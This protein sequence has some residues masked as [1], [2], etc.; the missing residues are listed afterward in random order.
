MPAPGLPAQGSRR[1]G[2][3]MED[4]G[5]FGAPEPRKSGGAIFHAADAM[6]EYL[7]MGDAP[8]CHTCGAIMVRNGSCYRCMSCGSTIFAV[9]L[10]VMFPLW[11]FKGRDPDPGISIAPM[12]EPPKG[13]S[14]AECGTLLDD[15]IHPRRITSTMV[16]LAVRGYIKIEETAEKGLVF[17][18]KDYVFHLLK[19]R[20]QW[21][22][23]APHEKA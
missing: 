23:L 16:D 12:Y 18:H 19:P 15:K 5:I 1:S 17:T 21:S 8:S 10:A 2:F 3:N 20:E 4:R 11:W 14:P 13:V 9:T 7:D 6:K 22:D